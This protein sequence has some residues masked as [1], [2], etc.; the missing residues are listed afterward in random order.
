[1]EQDFQLGTTDI[2]ERCPPVHWS[3]FSSIPGNS[4]PG[5][6]TLLIVTI[7]ND[8]RESLPQPILLAHLKQKY[9]AVIP[10]PWEAEAG[11]S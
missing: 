7:N 4:I 1:M 5:S 6:S 8:F 11:G 3:M 2:W 10:A 9:R